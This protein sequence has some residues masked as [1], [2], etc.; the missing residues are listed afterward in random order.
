M[1]ANDDQIIYPIP[2]RPGVA[3]TVKVPK[4]LT[5][6]EAEKIARVLVALAFA[7]PTGE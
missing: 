4:D 7:V 3:A 5:R 2:L 6:D 1:D